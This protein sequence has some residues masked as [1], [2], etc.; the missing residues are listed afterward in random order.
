MITLLSNILIPIAIC[1]ILIAV[2]LLLH[3]LIQGDEKFVIETQKHTP[4][5]VLE[6][7]SNFLVVSTNIPYSNYGKQICM[8]L[9]IF[10][11]VL[12]PQ[13]QYDKATVTAHLEQAHAPR[14][15][16]YFE[17]FMVYPNKTGDLTLT[18]RFFSPLLS[19][20][21]SLKDI[22]DVTI[23]IY[24]NGIGRNEMFIRKT[25]LV[26]QKEELVAII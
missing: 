26:V 3:P 19:I 2:L 6:R 21:D 11:R 1:A 5:K 10:P 14:A 13:E 8:V 16:E 4:L 17:A 22:F 7:G 24:S 20:E 18:L 25:G 9:D 23:N 15:D 12:L